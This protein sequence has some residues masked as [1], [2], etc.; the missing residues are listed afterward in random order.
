MASALSPGAT[1]ESLGETRL[2][3]AWRGTHAAKHQASLL[4]LFCRYRLVG[5]PLLP[6]TTR[7]RL[8]LIS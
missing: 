4:P 3:I 7:S 2:Q 5:R 8:P 6:G 1:P